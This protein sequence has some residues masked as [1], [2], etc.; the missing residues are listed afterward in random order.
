MQ[1]NLSKRKGII[2]EKTLIS[3]IDFG[4]ILNVGYCRC[5]D[6]TELSSL[7]FSNTGEGFKKF[8]SK[9]SWMKTQHGLNEVIVGF[10]STGPYAEPLMHFLKKRGVKLVQVNAAHTK[11]IKDIYDNSPNKTDDKDPKVIAD[12]IE[13]GRFLT[14]VIPEGVVAELRRLIHTRER[15]VERQK[16]CYNQ[17]HDAVYLVFPEFWNVMKGLK[18]LTSHHLLKTYPT[19]ET[20]LNLGF[21]G[22]AEVVAQVSRRRLGLERADA[23]YTSAEASVGLQDGQN[24]I[25]DEIKQL[26]SLID[27]CDEFIKKIEETLAEQLKEVPYS[28]FMLSIKGVGT[29]TV[30]GLIG[31]VGDFRKFK[32]ISELLKYA[33]LNLFEISSGRHKGRRKISKRGRPL[34]RKLL[35]FAAL[36]AVRKDG[37]LHEQYESYINRGMIKLKAMVAII[38]KLLGILFAMVRDQC[39]YIENYSNTQIV[40]QAA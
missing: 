18:T 29:V 39:Q 3:T 33:G 40:K 4:K 8:W 20:I 17:L 37:I 10:E 24:G 11:K 34:I 7:E 35:Y 6:G 36:N 15:H 1:S 27:S 31:E 21:S 28:R 25:V 13:L 22:L 5:P 2:S 19:P 16:T 9:V 32:T 12:L 26:L 38:R 14:V 30:S 23:L